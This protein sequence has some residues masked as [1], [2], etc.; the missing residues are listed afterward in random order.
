MLDIKTIENSIRKEAS[1]VLGRVILFL[2]YY[3]LLIL[4]GIGLFVGAFWIS[5]MLL[6]LLS[7]LESINVR[8][9]FW[10]GIAWLAM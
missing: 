7:E 9:I 3:I 10:G 2:V 1:T 6:G 4:V 5:W 8:L